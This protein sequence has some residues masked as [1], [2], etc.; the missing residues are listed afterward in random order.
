ME[1]NKVVDFTLLNEA[2]QPISISDFRGKPVVIYFYP[3]DNTPGCTT[4]A[5]QYKELYDEFQKLGVE[6]IGISKDG[7]KSHQK[8]KRDHD[9]P[10]TLLTDNDLNIT[11]Q[12][13]FTGQKKV[14]KN[15]ILGIIRSS[16]VIDEE[17]KLIKIFKGCKSKED[18]HVVLKFLKNRLE[19]E[20]K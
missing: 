5:S 8:F 13:G 3:K 11:T 17:G 10:F 18:A 6:I 15:S 2:G 14:M 7:Q 1:L 4:Q 9:L 16:I 20:K 12:L 19:E